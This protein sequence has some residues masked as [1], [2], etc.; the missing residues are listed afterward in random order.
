MPHSVAV[1]LRPIRH[2]ALDMD[3]TLYRGR[4]VFPFA[5]AALDAL[6]AAGI[7]Y[8]LLT[9]NSSLSVADYLRKLA[10]MGLSITSDQLHTS[11]QATIA[12]LAA[13]HPQANRWY[14]LG[15]PSM[16]AELR[17]AGFDVLAAGVSQDGQA[18]P[19]GQTQ[20]ERQAEPDGVLV[21][22]DRSLSYESLCRAAY[23]I[24]RGKLFV[25]THPDRVCP[26]DEATVLI[27]CGAICAALESA[28]GRAPDVVLGKPH[29][30]MLAGILARHG[31]AAHELAVVGDRLYTDLEMARRAGALGVLVLTG[32]ATRQMAESSPV[33]PDMIVQ[34]VREFAERLVGAQPRDRPRFA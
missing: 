1:R 18:E 5:R 23:W 14:V 28:T 30:Q 27:D 17:A 24:S 8:T 33:R 32:E 20:P 4:T 11:T 6:S 9:N 29:P 21:G 15:T 22:F 2:V 16:C 31:L 19:T 26:T 7:G 13:Q 3:G 25:A 12:H 34:D 10:G